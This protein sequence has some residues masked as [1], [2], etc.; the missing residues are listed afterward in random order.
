MPTST[1]IARYYHPGELLA[2][3][4]HRRAYGFRVNTTHDFADVLL[5]SSQCAARLDLVCIE[6]G[7]QQ[8]FIEIHPAQV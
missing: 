1:V 2:E 5:L 8:I 6:H 3:T 7:V 4:F